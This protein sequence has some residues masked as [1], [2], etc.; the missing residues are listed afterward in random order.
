MLSEWS[1]TLITTTFRN[2]DKEDLQ[3]KCEVQFYISRAVIFRFRWAHMDRL[4]GLV[5]TLSGY[6][7]RGLG[8]DAWLYQI[9]W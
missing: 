8:F 6:R 4:R 3:F 2:S 9:F 7:S 1:W 5:V